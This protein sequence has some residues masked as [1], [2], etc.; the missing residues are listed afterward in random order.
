[1]NRQRLLLIL[2]VL[3]LGGLLGWWRY[4]EWREHRF[5]A[6][7]LEASRR[8]GVE[9]EL[10]KAVV[11]CESRFNPDA[12]GRAGE[13]GL[14]Q[15]RGAAAGEWAAAE[16]INPFSHEQLIDP[17]TN[18]LAGAWYLAKLLKR[19]RQVGDPVP[20]ALADYNAGR[21]NVLRWNKGPAATNATD[22]LARLDFPG[23]RRYVNEVTRRREKYLAEWGSERRGRRGVTE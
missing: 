14:M 18:T 10:V 15:I 7:I 2:V 19:Y 16:R 12:R 6:L 22:F 23:T 21:S 13:L 1:M 17:A 4:L 9:P 20:Y 8:Y 3:L 11:W 5:D